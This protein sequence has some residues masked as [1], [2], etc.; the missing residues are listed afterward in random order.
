MSYFTRNEQYIPHS[1]YLIAKV[2]GKWKV[3]RLEALTEIMSFKQGNKFAPSAL[4]STMLVAEKEK[5]NWAF[6]FSQKLQNK[7]IAI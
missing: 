4:I 7:I 6:W 5:V 3:A 1:R 2:D